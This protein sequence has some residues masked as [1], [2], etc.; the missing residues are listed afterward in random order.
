MNYINAYYF[1][2]SVLAKLFIDEHE[3]TKYREIFFKYPVRYV[4]TLCLMETLSVIKCRL[5]NKNKTKEY[6]GAVTD[7]MS[8]IKDSNIEVDD[9]NISSNE[10]TNLAIN[11]IEKHDIDFSDAIQIIS[12]KKSSLRKHNIKC[13]LVSTDKNLIEAARIYGIETI[14][15]I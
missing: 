1:D 4:T 13:Y 9:L 3:S 14:E 7:L 11:I 8:L 15:N 2:A 6:L 12:I 5:L 10:I